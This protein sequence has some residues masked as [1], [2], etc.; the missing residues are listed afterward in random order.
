MT[1]ALQQYLDSRRTTR[2][3]WGKHDCAGFAA[4]ALDALLGTDYVGIVR[5]HGVL[6]ARTYRA[7]LRTGRTLEALTRDV[8]GIPTLI[9]EHDHLMRGDIVL[10]GRGARAALGVVAPPVLLV[11]HEV[12]FRP[13][14][15]KAATLLWRRVR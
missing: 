10:V 4:G 3:T 9:S 8:L 11:A 15:M 5:A 6:S 1:D 7:M 12:G 14:P 2:F 13:L